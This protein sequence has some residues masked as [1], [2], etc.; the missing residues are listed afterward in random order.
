MYG[1][2]V[3]DG[4]VPALVVVLS[5]AGASNSQKVRGSRCRLNSARMAE[6]ASTSVSA[7]AISKEVFTIEFNIYKGENI[8]RYRRY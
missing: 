8:Y 4:L 1:F 6:S 5:H 7:W 2:Y 3:S